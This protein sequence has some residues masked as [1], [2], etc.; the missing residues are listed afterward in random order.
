LRSL[1]VPD[2]IATLL[3]LRRRQRGYSEGQ[4]SESLVLLHTVGG[5]CP[6]DIRLLANDPYLERGLGYRPP[7]VTAVREFL[8]LFHDKEIQRPAKRL[9]RFVHQPQVGPVSTARG[10]VA[11]LH[12]RYPSLL[13][14][15]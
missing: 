7:K 5:D 4:M 9:G 6:A 2:L 1:A 3:K 8:E 10:D 12:P 14:G 13:A 11:G 15:R